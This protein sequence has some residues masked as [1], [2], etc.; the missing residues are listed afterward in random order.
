MGLMPELKKDKGKFYFEDIEFK[1]SEES[2]KISIVN[3]LG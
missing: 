3:Q 1:K 2:W